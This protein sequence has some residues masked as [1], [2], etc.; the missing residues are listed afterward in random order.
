MMIELDGTLGE[1][2]GQ[3]LRSAL[4]LSLVTGRAFRLNHIRAKRRRPGLMRQHL[5]A[6]QAAA[7]IGSA[8]VTG[9][10]I[11]SRDLTFVPGAVRAGHYEFAVGTAGS[12]TLVLQAILPALLTAGRS[13]LVLEGGTHNP[14]APPFGHLAHTFVPALQR[15]GAHI[16]VEL[17]R[18][19]FYPAGGGKFVVEIEPTERLAPTDFLER[20]ATVRIHACAK[21]ANLPRSIAKRELEIIRRG[22]ALSGPELEVA[23]VTDAQG[24]G[25]IVNIMVESEHAREVCTGF[26]E[27]KRSAERVARHALQQAREYLRADAPVGQHL[28]DQLLIPMALAG[29]G[30]FRTLPLSDHATTNA[31]IVAA[32]LPVEITVEQATGTSR[33]VHIRKRGTP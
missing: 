25:N 12:A 3:I 30:S 4:G 28:A 29:G 26:G 16:G 6:V 7:T 32:F 2:G 21:V 11:G 10:A 20:G 18:H 31:L 13:T 14:W 9:A 15:M 33:I 24:P 17:Q 8:E 23:V 5:T 27:P 19:G 1:G 22:L